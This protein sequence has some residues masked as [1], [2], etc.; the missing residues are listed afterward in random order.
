M[1]FFTKF[2]LRI[3]RMNNSFIFGVAICF[4]ALSAIL[5]YKLEPQTFESYF[6]GLWWVMTTVTTVGYGDY[7][8]QT[9]A[10]KCLGI[11]VYIFGIG[12]ISVTISKIV[13]SLFMYQRMKEEGKLRYTGENHFVII[14]WSKHA[15]NAIKEILNTDPTTDIVLIDTL[16]KTPISHNRVHF[17]QGSPLQPDTLEMSNISK[18]RAVFIFADD[19]ALEQHALKDPAFVDGKT[20]LVATAIERNYNHV[21]T[22]VEVRN[23]EN[24]ENFKHI[25]I[26]EF[27]FGSETISQLA[28]RSAFNPG[29]SKILSQLLT[30]TYGEDLY[31]ITKDERWVTY[32]DAFQD[33]LRQGATLISDGENLNINKRLHEPIPQNARLFVICDKDTYR[34]LCS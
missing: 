5:A 2:F 7:Y 12:I 32:H 27:I 28:V 3:I 11:V 13:D 6:N 25:K 23:K 1:I 9:V 29:S 22:I 19:T 31:E 24:L 26:D 15:E 30:R 16:D 10:G 34:Q 33:L 20:L 18:A 4:I 8:P 14:A 17:I 21:Y